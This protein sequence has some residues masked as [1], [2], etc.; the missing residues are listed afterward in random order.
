[1]YKSSQNSFL[2]TKGL[3]LGLVDLWQELVLMPVSIRYKCVCMCV[4]MTYVAVI[5]KYYLGCKCT[6]GTVVS[7]QFLGL[8]ATGGMVGYGILCHRLTHHLHLYGGYQQH[9]VCARVCVCVCV[10]VCVRVCVR[11]CV[12]VCAC[13]CVRACVCVYKWAGIEDCVCN[14]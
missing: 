9:C 4:D 6:Y 13:A 12:C 8:F 2:K 10:C 1:M 3:I 5:L 7:H 14:T 11:A